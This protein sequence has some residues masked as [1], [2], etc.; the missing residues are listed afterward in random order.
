MPDGRNG[1]LQT[2]GLEPV[3]TSESRC[4]SSITQPA[5]E[6]IH[7]VLFE[8]QEFYTCRTLILLMPL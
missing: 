8:S 4:T 7:R 6:C 3:Q 1:R 5:R 2:R